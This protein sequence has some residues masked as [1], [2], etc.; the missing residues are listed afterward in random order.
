M[1]VGWGINLIDLQFLYMISFVVSAIFSVL[2]GTS[3]GSAATIG[4]VLIGVCEAVGANSGIAA[5]AII[6]GCYFGDKLSPLSD[7]TNVA[8][9]AA[10]ADLFDHIRAMLWTTLPSA[11]IA[12]VVYSLLGFETDLES[13]KSTQVKTMELL[14]GLQDLFEASLI[15]LSPVLVVLLGAIKKWPTIPILLAS[16][17]LSLIHI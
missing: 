3:W 4:V 1:L 17:I 15:L 2:T 8:A 12:I 9:I 16:I 5:G 14:R 6:G 11:S 10:R 7:T 13:S